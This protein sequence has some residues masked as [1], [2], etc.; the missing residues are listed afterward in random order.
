MEKFVS[1][2]STGSKFRREGERG[3]EERTK[4]KIKERSDV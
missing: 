2:L 1:K 4:I 3:K